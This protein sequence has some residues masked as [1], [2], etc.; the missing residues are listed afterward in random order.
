MNQSI[1]PPRGLF[2]QNLWIEQRVD[3]I[4]C[5]IERYKRCGKE[6]PNEWTFEH[7]RLTDYLLQTDKSNNSSI[8]I[9]VEV[10]TIEID[11]AMKKLEDMSRL[12]DKVK[13]KINKLHTSDV[14][15]INLVK[16]GE[17]EKMSV[18]FKAST[19]PTMQDTLKNLNSLGEEITKS[20]LR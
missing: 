7:K 16:V 19:L 6:I 20:T 5:A 1:K 3:D 17:V 2:P 13:E 9:K 15:N 12:L 8:E 14:Q 4:N 10:D 18:S 11:I